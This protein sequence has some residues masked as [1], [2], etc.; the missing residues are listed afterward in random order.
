MSNSLNMYVLGPS[1]SGKTGLLRQLRCMCENG[2]L[3]TQPAHDVP[4]KG[5]EIHSLIVHAPQK[6][7][8]FCTVE[9]CELGGEMSPVW[10]KFIRSRLGLAKDKNDQRCALMFVVDALAPHLL[11]LASVLFQRLKCFDG[12][13]REWP[14]V[15]VLNKVAARNA[16]TEGE[17]EF[18]IPTASYEATQVLCVDSWNGHG[19]GDLMKWVNSVA[20]S[21]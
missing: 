21:C 3:M 11:P 1:A 9:L 17:L 16:M 12:L 7:N 10:E 20:F 18:F 15:V 5:Q 2:T 6:K 13:C 14:A 8:V 19:I 4:T